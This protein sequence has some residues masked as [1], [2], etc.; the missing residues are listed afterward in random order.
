MQVDGNIRKCSIRPVRNYDITVD[1]DA[2]PER[3]WE[4]MIDVE[5]WHEWTPSITSI[6]RLD[7]GEFREGSRVRIKQP[8]LAATVMTVTHLEPGR[9]F[10]WQTRAPGL[11]VTAGHSVTPVGNGSQARLTL[12]FDGFV[13]GLFAR[14]MRGLN[15]RYVAYEAAGLKKRSENPPATARLR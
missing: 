8:K 7:T 12:Y 5:R 13:G 9:S 1:I 4:V 14:A 6:K 10:T 2:P 11:E 3:V 15:E